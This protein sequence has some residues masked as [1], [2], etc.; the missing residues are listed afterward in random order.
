MAGRGTGAAV[1]DAEIGLSAAR[2]PET[3]MPLLAAFRRGL[4]E[5]GYVEGKN[6][7]IEYRWGGSQVDR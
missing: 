6:V 7:A 2:A 3:E 1:G 5:T 4:N